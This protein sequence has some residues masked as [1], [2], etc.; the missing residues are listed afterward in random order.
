MKRLLNTCVCVLVCVGPLSLASGS[1]EAGDLAQIAAQMRAIL[2]ESIGHLE[3][4]AERVNVVLVDL[5]TGYEFSEQEGLRRVPLLSP[6][7]EGMVTLSDGTRVPVPPEPDY[8]ASRRGWGIVFVCNNCIPSPPSDYAPHRRVKSNPGYRKAEGYVVLPS[9]S[10][11]DGVDQQGE[12]AYNFFGLE[13]TGI[14]AEAGI[15]SGP[16]HNKTWYV[17]GNFYYDGKRHWLEDG[18]PPG[19]IPAGTTVFM[20]M[21]VP[22]DNQLVLY[23]SYGSSSKTFLYTNVPGTKEN[24][25]G[26]RIR[27][28][29][30]LILNSGASGKL[31]ND[32][33]H[34]VY[35]AT[36]SDMH[37][38]VPSDTQTPPTTTACVT[39]TETNPY[40][41]EAISIQMP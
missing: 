33:W 9:T 26:Q 3:D 5:L 37:L 31:L 17:F 34:D 15:F 23:V 6:D 12:A 8:R 22:Q 10:D 30:S 18:W 4:P 29:T 16:S 21:Y 11:F 35:I 41:N 36:S 38:W 24:G 25:S 13:N 14:D 1:Q 40:Y 20:R 19:G 39:V 27:R 7:A 32:Q 2:Q 28:P